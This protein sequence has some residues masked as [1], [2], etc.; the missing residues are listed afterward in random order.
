M[1]KRILGLLWVLALV[2]ALPAAA[3]EGPTFGWPSFDFMGWI[4]DWLGISDDGSPGQEIGGVAEP[5]GLE[6]SPSA[7]MGP[8]YEPGG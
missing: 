8:I 5:W 2:L 1:R 6:D 7:E 4:A 3:A